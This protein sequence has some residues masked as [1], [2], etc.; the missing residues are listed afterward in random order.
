MHEVEARAGTV[1]GFVEFVLC[2]AGH[3]MLVDLAGAG[4]YRCGVP[5]C[6]FVLG[7]LSDGGNAQQLPGVV[8]SEA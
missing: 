7:R 1:G 8:E 3:W 5:G 4:P 6:R 2:P